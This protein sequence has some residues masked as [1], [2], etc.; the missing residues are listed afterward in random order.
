MRTFKLSFTPAVTAHIIQISAWY[1]DQRKGLGT[2]F[3][4]NLKAELAKIK[5]NPFTSSFR[6][7]TVRFAVVKKIPTPYIILLMKITMQL[8]FMQ[9]LGLRK[10]QRSGENKYKLFYNYFSTSLISF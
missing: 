9:F 7:D 3:K 2:R 1:N 8:S 6:Y 10:I 5:K 4:D